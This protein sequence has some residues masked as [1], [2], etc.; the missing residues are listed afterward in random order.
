MLVKRGLSSLLDSSSLPSPLIPI[1]EYHIIGMLFLDFHPCLD[2]LEVEVLD[3]YTQL[4]SYKD[5]SLQLYVHSLI[6]SFW[7]LHFRV[8]TDNKRK[9]G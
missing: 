9:I 6:H 4:S 1:V 5:H 7:S 2:Q 3:E 8:K